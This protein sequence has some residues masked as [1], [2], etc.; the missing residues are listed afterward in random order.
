MPIYVFSC[1]DC[2]PFELT[3]PMAE[4]GKPAHC[5]ICLREARRVFT[6]PRLAR[7][8]RPLRQ[9]LE[10]EEASAYEPG[11]VTQKRGRPLPQRPPP[12][13]PWVLHQH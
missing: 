6:P 5:P 12:T 7:L 2:G 4:T 8:A 13:P 9:V 11:V 10:K 3:R 1:R